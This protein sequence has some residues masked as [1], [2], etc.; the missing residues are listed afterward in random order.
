MTDVEGPPV[1]LGNA[2]K[3]IIGSCI[4]LPDEKIRLEQSLGRFASHPHMALEPLPGYDGALRD[5]YAVGGESIEKGLQAAVYTIVDEVA[6][7]DTRRLH[8]DAGEAIRIMTGG[9][10]PEECQAVVPQ[11]QC[12]V[13]GNVLTVPIAP[14]RT[15]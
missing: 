11:E 5:G 15:A 2:Q 1:T 14:L 13:A 7:G 4:L 8:L 10:I 3:L 12:H 9:L 6:A